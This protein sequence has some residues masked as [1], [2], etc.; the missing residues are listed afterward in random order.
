[1]LQ[2]L[3]HNCTVVLQT[4]EGRTWK[5]RTLNGAKH[6]DPSS[7]ALCSFTVQ[8]L[9]EGLVKLKL[10]AFYD[11]KLGHLHSLTYA[12]DVLVLADSPESLQKLAAEV[13]T[14]STKY[15]LR[16]NPE[17]SALVVYGGDKDEPGV[18]FDGK[19][20][21]RKT[22]Y[23][24]LRV[25]TFDSAEAKEARHARI[26]LAQAA[27][28]RIIEAATANYC[29]HIVPLV[30]LWDT[31]V[32]P[33]TLYAT[34]IWGVGCTT[35]DWREM[36]AT[37]MSF[38]SQILCIPRSTP[39]K[40]MLAELGAYPLEIHALIETIRFIARVQDMED[41]RPTRRLMELALQ[42][43][44]RSTWGQLKQ[45]LQRWGLPADCPEDVTEEEIKEAYILKT[46]ADNNP[47]DNM[48]FYLDHVRDQPLDVENYVMQDYLKFQLP[49]ET[50]TT[51][52]RCRTRTAPIPYTLQHWQNVNKDRTCTRCHN[53]VDDVEHLF[54]K[55]RET[56]HHR[57]KFRNLMRPLPT[58]KQFFNME[59][60]TLME[61]I[62]ACFAPMELTCLKEAQPR[63]KK[64]RVL[65]E[66]AKGRAKRARRAVGA[67]AT[68][69]QVKDQHLRQASLA[70][71]SASEATTV[72]KR[73]RIN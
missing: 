47:S 6:G 70:Q 54:L 38:V 46:W 36:Q 42:N 31:V 72:S 22:E 61:Y 66:T 68:R 43:K 59:P 44:S 3:Y 32:I 35:K 45:W 1:M 19:E 24:H 25:M 67:A 64:T 62:Q 2:L 9:E 30:K 23:K 57:E 4:E 52:V 56:E 17:K 10:G 16:I 18:F 29:K 41:T 60:R 5:I 28:A 37:A 71:T 26:A 73:Q 34:A 11:D 8:K 15:F 63:R 65:V 40:V 50:I 51:I 21:P 55:C 12:D 58:L 7:P 49:Q 39:T 14:F 33:T 53:G 13:Q 27:T 69:A 20:I 48:R